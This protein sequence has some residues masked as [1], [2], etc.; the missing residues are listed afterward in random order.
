MTKRK[1]ETK[2]ARPP[3]R[4]FMLDQIA[5]AYLALAKTHDG[6]D[7]ER[8]MRLYH[9]VVNN[10]PLAPYQSIKVSDS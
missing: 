9:G 1:S 2:R 3:P 4:P 7:R 5:E 10:P 6:E 8:F